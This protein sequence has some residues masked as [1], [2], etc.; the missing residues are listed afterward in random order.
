MVLRLL[1]LRGS[2]MHILAWR[3]LLARTIQGP[4]VVVI[5]LSNRLLLQVLHNRDKI[6]IHRSG[7]FILAGPSDE[8]LSR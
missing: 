8:L 3:L 2:H 1:R 6:V 7:V 5:R 4:P